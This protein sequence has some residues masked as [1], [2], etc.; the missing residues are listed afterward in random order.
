ML[1]HS[2]FSLTALLILSSQ[3]LAQDDKQAAL[4][5]KGQAT[6]TAV[7]A[8]CHGS[9]GVSI[10]AANPSL[11]GMPATYIVSQLKAFKSDMRNNAVMKGFAATLSDDDMKAVGA[12]FADQKPRILGYKDKALAAEGQA[13][14]RAG[15]ASRQIPAC[16]GCHSPTG[17]G[18]AQYARLGGQYSEYT[19]AQLTAYKTGARGANPKDTNGNVMAAIAG[20]L[21]DREIKALAEYVQGLK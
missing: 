12:Y 19:I 16:A 9:D 18:M 8:A 3:A 17:A 14:Y 11:A 15:V 6:A 21:T 7:C 2:F 5:A 13:I 10:S 20:R 1:R 4:L